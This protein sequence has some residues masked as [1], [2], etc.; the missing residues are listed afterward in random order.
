MKLEYDPRKEKANIGKHDVDFSTVEEVFADPFQLIIP[1]NS[2]ST[3][4]EKD[5]MPSA[6]TAEE[7]LLS[8]SRCAAA[9][10]AS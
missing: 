5:S 3:P 9:P 10:S 6:M 7:F 8:V 4:K 1:N 2:H